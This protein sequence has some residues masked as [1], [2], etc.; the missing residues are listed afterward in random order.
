MPTFPSSAMPTLTPARQDA[1]HLLGTPLPP[2]DNAEEALQHGGLTGWNVRKTPLFAHFGPRQVQV[3]DRSAVI[4]DDIHAVEGISVL[5]DVGRWYQV[6]QNEDLA[7]LLDVL[8]EEAGATFDTAGMIDGGKLVY[9]TMKLPGRIRVGGKDTVENYLAAVTGHDGKVSTSLMITPVRPSAGALLNLAFG[10]ASNQFRIRHTVGAARILEEQAAEALEFTFNYLDQFQSTAEEL[11]G[12]RVSQSR[13]EQL[14]AGE[15]GAGSS[16]ALATQTRGQNKLDQM[17][18]LFATAGMGEGMHET[19]WAGLC[20]LAEWHDHYSPV[21]GAVPETLTRSR[22]ALLDP[23]F[24]NT[25]LKLMMAE[26]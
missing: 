20:A 26:V 12:A 18:E 25:A 22:K 2:T 10:G 5:G 21:R 16:A 17:A 8:A 23:E 11:I 14:I 1:W 15:F 9:V 6:L 3:P 24:K 7:G 13:F 19:A 4:R